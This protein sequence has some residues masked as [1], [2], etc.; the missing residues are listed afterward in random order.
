MGMAIVRF[1]FA[2][3]INLIPEMSLANYEDITVY[4]PVTASAKSFATTNNKDGD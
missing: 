2:G 4:L 3:H 1:S